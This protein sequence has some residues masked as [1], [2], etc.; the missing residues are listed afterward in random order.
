V[1]TRLTGG[2]PDAIGSG[3]T[4]GRASGWTGAVSISIYLL[5]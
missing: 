1:Y 5:H 4:L 2:I 3:L